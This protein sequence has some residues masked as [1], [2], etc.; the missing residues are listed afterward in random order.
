MVYPTSVVA[1]LLTWNYPILY[2][3]VGTRLSLTDNKINRASNTH[4]SITTYI[5]TLP[6]GCTPPGFTSTGGGVAK[7][8]GGG[9]RRA[10]GV[11]TLLEV[12]CLTVRI[13]FFD[14]LVRYFFQKFPRKFQKFSFWI[15]ILE[16]GHA[17]SRRL[18]IYGGGVWRNLRRRRLAAA[19]S[20]DTQDL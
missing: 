3:Y 4:K 6:Q 12:I 9:V 11:Y 2:A 19:C 15:I 13:S 7:I 18:R 14:F 17:G 5:S 16:T 1:Q 20:T 10:G 8:C